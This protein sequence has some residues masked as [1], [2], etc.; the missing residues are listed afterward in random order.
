MT[1]VIRFL[2]GLALIV[3]VAACGSA[4]SPEARGETAAAGPERWTLVGLGDSFTSTQN[5]SGRSYL[6]LFQETLETAPGRTVEL[7]DLSRDDNTTAR[8]ADDLRHDQTTRDAVSAA[9]IVLVSV[10]GNDG[11]PFGV[12]P[13][14]TC[15]PGQS[16]TACLQAYAPEFAANY[17][18]IL[19][20]I[21][22]LRAGKPTALRVTSADNPFVGWSQAPS[23]AFGVQFYRQ[24]AEAETQ[25][26]CSAA[27]R[28]HGVCIDYL[29]LFGGADGSTD[30]A[31]FL[32]PD[33]AHPGDA[34]IKAIAG[35]LAAAGVPE[36]RAQ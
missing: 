20:E 6:D 14:G 32:G 12:Y 29:H 1:A 16:A 2:W 9:D 35:L 15:A 34:G 22:A 28:H 17:E 27:T 26:A 18:S 13:S 19:S 36:L 33:H 21:E 3:L 25:A 23:K 7:R 31:P 30:P 11:D 5:S 24:V 8:L 4:G 10:G